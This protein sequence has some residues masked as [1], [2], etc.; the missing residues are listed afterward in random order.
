MHG[1]NF[2]LVGRI[3][4]KANIE[5]PPYASHSS[6]CAMTICSTPNPESATKVKWH[7]LYRDAFL[8]E[9]KKI[10]LCADCKEASGCMR[11]NEE[12]L[13]FFF[14]G[15]STALVRHALSRPAPPCCAADD[16]N[17]EHF[18]CSLISLVWRERARSHKFLAAVHFQLKLLKL[19]KHMQN[20]CEIL[21]VRWQNTC[22]VR[23]LNCVEVSLL[24]PIFFFF[25]SFAF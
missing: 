21:S 1:M 5:L 15:K 10:K 6:L 18:I 3:A 24:F 2:W 23:R 22:V 12:W 9:M 19:C 13:F 7:F 4:R 8:P 17:R 20:M 11:R 14:K 16:E 25:L